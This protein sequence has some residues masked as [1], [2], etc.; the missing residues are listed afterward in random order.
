M[1]PTARRGN[2][3]VFFLTLFLLLSGGHLGS[4]DALQQLR[5]SILLAST[6]AL[7]VPWGSAPVP[8]GWVWAPNGRIYEPHDL[9]NALLFLPASFA[10]VHVPVLGSATLFDAPTLAVRAGAS[11]MSP[12]LAAFACVWCLELLLPYTDVRRA[13]G[14]AVAFVFAT[15]F[16]AYARTSWDV[17][18]AATFMCAVLWQAG[19]MLR[20]PNATRSALFATAA[21]AAAC[22]F[23]YSLL[24]FF[25]PATAA[26][27]GVAVMRG[28]LSL[29]D[30]AATALL[31][32]LLILPTLTYNFIRTGSPLRPATAVAPY[33]DGP[34]SL[35]GDII[36]GFSGLLLSPKHGLFVYS[37]L[38]LMA[39]A[40]LFVWR[41]LPDPQRLLL[42]AFGTGTVLYMLLIAKMVNWGT[43]GWGP[44]Y[45]VPV[46][47]V[48]FFAAAC[49]S[50]QFQGRARAAILIL[51]ACSC[52][53]T[54]PAAVVDWP[55]VTARV[56]AA[57]DHRSAGPSQLLTAW[58][59]MMGADPSLLVPDW[60]LWRVAHVSPVAAMAAGVTAT[61][62]L[63]TL[64]LTGL[65]LCRVRN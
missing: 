48:F 46:L 36:Q 55:S 22:T 40:V 52:L 32:G 50:L 39:I 29:R 25:V 31:F 49:A 24:P 14:L 1:S 8:G 62:G 57:V 37:P 17:L 61:I 7:G 13:F 33:I 4:S 41:R 9:G 54:L 53:W 43:F 56:E 26:L 21:L 15:P 42:A 60:F 10:A 63:F 45:L 5:S 47:P 3:F 38:L 23:R 65:T 44:R 28:R 64:G 11:L 16:V 34:L 20:G 2:A 18:G 58:H 30:A 27:V 59:V 51:A 19:G 35:N 6:G 12:V